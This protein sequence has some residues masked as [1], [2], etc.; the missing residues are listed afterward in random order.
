MVQGTTATAVT[1][2]NT[3]ALSGTSVT[4]TATVTPLP[5]GSLMGGTVTFRR[6]TTT[7]GTG[8]LNAAGQ[9]TLSTTTL[10][11]GTHSVTAVYAGNGAYLG[12][13]SPAMSQVIS[14]SA[15]I[16]GQV[17]RCMR[18]RTTPSVRSVVQ[19][20]VEGATG[21]RLPPLGDLHG[22]AVRERAA[23]EVGR[24]V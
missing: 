14:P 9:A 16:E 6:G 17:T 19:T 3:N 13:T 4:L 21:A 12:S 8:V 22:H 5:A 2:S 20:P 23:E 11:V 1:S 24:R 18:C 10:P 15:T 7:I